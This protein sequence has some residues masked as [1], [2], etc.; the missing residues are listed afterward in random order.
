MTTTISQ[1]PTIRRLQHELNTALDELGTA[2]ARLSERTEQYDSAVRQRDVEARRVSDLARDL[3]TVRGQLQL[4]EQALGLCRAHFTKVFERRDFEAMTRE[5]LVSLAEGSI[6]EARRKGLVEAEGLATRH[7]QLSRETDLD[8]MRGVVREYQNRIA[9]VESELKTDTRPL[10]AKLE[11]AK[12]APFAAPSWWDAHPK[13]KA[14]A[15]GFVPFDQ[16][17]SAITAAAKAKEPR[18]MHDGAVVTVPSAVGGTYILSRRGDVYSCTCPAWRWG[19][20]PT[21]R[22]TCK[23]LETY[24]GEKQEAERITAY[25]KTECHCGEPLVRGQ[26]QV[27]TRDWKGD[28]KCEC[29]RKFASCKA[30]YDTISVAQ[31]KYGHQPRLAK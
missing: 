3:A 22:R 4:S 14:E 23:H 29:G 8:L 12:P 25:L 27:H 21:N 17:A 16:R 5:Q 15:G 19:R 26:C 30:A 24:L 10:S 31:R 9:E 13:V 7:A 1:G 20:A 2:R 28:E 11:P 6:A 18:E